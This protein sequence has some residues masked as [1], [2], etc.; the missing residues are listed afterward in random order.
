MPSRMNIKTEQSPGW[1]YDTPDDESRA[2]CII[3]PQADAPYPADIAP[4]YNWKNRQAWLSQSRSLLLVPLVELMSFL[5]RNASASSAWKLATGNE[6]LRR[7]WCC[8]SC[9][10]TFQANGRQTLK[11]AK[12]TWRIPAWELAPK[13]PGRIEAACITKQN[14]NSGNAWYLSIPSIFIRILPVNSSKRGLTSQDGEIWKWYLIHFLFEI[15]SLHSEMDQTRT[16]RRKT[17]QNKH[18][19]WSSDI[20]E[21]GPPAGYRAWSSRLIGCNLDAIGQALWHL[22]HLRHVCHRGHRTPGHSKTLKMLPV[23]DKARPHPSEGMNNTKA[24]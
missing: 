10:A 22:R 1:S 17:W 8:L 23:R 13:L 2:L 3:E 9:T 12:T 16:L 7:K 15:Q 20:Y 21:L 19:S 11:H 4:V 5:R 6:R 24:K 18:G 14:F